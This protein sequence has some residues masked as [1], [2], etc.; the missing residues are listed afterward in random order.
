MRSTFKRGA[1]RVGI[2]VLALVLGLVSHPGHTEVR[3]RQP[4]EA[5]QGADP[6]VPHQV[7]RIGPNLTEELHC[8]ALNVY[9]EARSETQTGKIAVAMVTLN[10][11]GHRQFPDTV[12]GVVRQGGSEA[13]YRCQFSWYCDGKDDEPRRDGLWRQA[14]EVARKVVFT[15]VEDPTGGALFFHATHVNPDWSRRLRR[16]TRIGGHVYYTSRG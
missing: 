9:F 10:R 2:V 4:G 3:V 1:H 11:A 6:P 16:T 13:R 15:R 12:C 14:Q 8:L 7:R 5:Q